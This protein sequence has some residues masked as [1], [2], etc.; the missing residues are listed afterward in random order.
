MTLTETCDQWR[1]KHPARAT[2]LRQ[3]VSRL[4]DCPLNSKLSEAAIVEICR[5]C[6]DQLLGIVYGL[7]D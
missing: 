5:P 6:E 7:S 4:L 2:A 1:A 3:R